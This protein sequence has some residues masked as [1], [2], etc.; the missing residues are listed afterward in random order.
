MDK[1]EIA[2]VAYCHG[3][4]DAIAMVGEQKL[5]KA[6]FE[7]YIKEEDVEKKHE[8]YNKI[9]FG[10]YK[11]VKGTLFSEFIDF[12]KLPFTQTIYGIVNKIENE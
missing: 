6:L 3:V 7:E 8:L 4:A 12:T 5:F 9:V 1:Q 10:I 2:K 11:I